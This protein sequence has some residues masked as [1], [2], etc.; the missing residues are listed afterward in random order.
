MTG[1]VLSGTLSHSFAESIR[2]SFT[3]YSLYRRVLV[4]GGCMFGKSVHGAAFNLAV[5]LY[6]IW[7][8]LGGSP[9]DRMQRTCQPILWAGNVTQS[10]TALTLPEYGQSVTKAFDN[11]DYACQYTL[12]RLFYEKD[13]IE[14]LKNQ[15]MSEEEISE[16]LRKLQLEGKPH[17]SEEESSE[18]NAMQPPDEGQKALEG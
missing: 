14:S 11:V 1:F 2:S 8:F 4:F 5:L 18:L 10:L 13:F 16:Y 17:L 9:D 7:V 12:W 6:I 15:G 3:A